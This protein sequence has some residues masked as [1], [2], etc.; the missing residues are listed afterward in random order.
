[1][2]Q[3]LTY[4]MKL[5]TSEYRNSKK[6]NAYLKKILEI[7]CATDTTAEELI[8]AFNIDLAVG[9]QLDILG[10]IIGRGRTVN[11]QPKAGMSA[12]LDDYYYRL[13]LKA[14][15][16]WNHW[17]GTLPQLIESWQM[18]CPEG[19]ILFFDNQNMS[20]DVVLIGEFSQMEKELIDNG[21][22]VPKPEGVRINFI[23][24][25]SPDGIPLFSYGYDN[26]LLG[27]YGTHWFNLDRYQIFG[28]GEE[29]ETIA[30][31]GTGYWA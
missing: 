6:F 12:V 8:E 7:L 26:E 14:K 22:I 29:N 10:L 2:K 16:V 21:Y 18:L 19:K 3:D 28:Y 25:E 27:G 20:M 5:V 24:I 17:N 31:Y 23:V 11:F 30:G 13:I 9:K 15:I 4:Y 1:M